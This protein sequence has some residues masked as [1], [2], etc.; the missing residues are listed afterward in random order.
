MHDSPF[1]AVDEP[2]QKLVQQVF[3]RMSW[4]WTTHLVQILL[5]VEVEV[6]EYKIKLVLSMHDVL[7]VDDMRVLQFL[8]ESDFSDGCAR[9]T[10][11]CV[12][13]SDLFQGND[14][15]TKLE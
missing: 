14:L 8:E 12:L 11:I 4:K 3:H 6:L 13:K 15:N 9:N 7:Q 1:V 10:F 5:H 2:L